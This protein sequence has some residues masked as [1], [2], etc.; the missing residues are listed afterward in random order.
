MSLYVLKA[1]MKGR[2]YVISDDPVPPG[3]WRDFYT[4][5]NR[6]DWS[7]PSYKIAR[8]SGKLGDVLGWIGGVPLFSERAVELLSGV[9]QN[10]LAFR[11]FGLIKKVR[12]FVA[13]RIPQVDSLDEQ[14]IERAGVAFCLRGEE[15]RLIVKDEVPQAVVAAG[16]T[17]FEFRAPSGGD[18]KKLFLG[19]DTN[20][21][22][23][24]I[25]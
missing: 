21:F 4:Q 18:L 6:P 10:A 13:C 9:T 7:P 23:G 24:V 11:M 2:P 14:S 5:G 16:L 17:G 12:Y 8:L 3:Y 19:Q 1:A 25:P 22:P 15:T 20:V